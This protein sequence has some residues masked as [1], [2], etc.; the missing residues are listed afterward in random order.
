MQLHLQNTWCGY[1]LQIF[2]SKTQA[3]DTY[4]RSN[5][6]TQVVNTYKRSFHKTQALDH[7]DTY[8]RSD[9]KT[10]VVDRPCRH[11]LQILSQTHVVDITKHMYTDT[12]Y[13]SYHK[14]NV[15]HTHITDYITKHNHV[16]EKLK[17]ISQN[18]CRQNKTYCTFSD[19]THD[20]DPY[21]RSSQNICR[22][23]NITDAVI[24]HML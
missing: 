17:I 22:Q 9:Y 15:W 13:R 11:I 2:S 10:N 18:T 19:K 20:V 12:Y 21:Y 6:K 24:K 4:Y 23:T 8:Y 1:L 5:Y 16:V 7:V 3:L 14:T